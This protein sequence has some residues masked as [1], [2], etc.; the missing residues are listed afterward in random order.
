MSNAVY[1]ALSRQ[2]GLSIEIQKVANNLANASTTGYK[3]DRAVFSEYIVAT[4]PDSDSLSMGRLVG[5]SIELGQ[6]AMRFTGGQLDVAIE[7]EGFFTVETDR[8]VRLSR[9]GHFQLS[10]EGNLIDAN[11]YGVLSQGGGAIAI[12]QGAGQISI[13]DDGT[14]SADGNVIDQIGVVTTEGQLLRDADTLFI[15]QGGYQPATEAR[16]LQGALEQSNVSPVMEVTRMIEVQRAYEAGQA[17]LERE[18][19]R[20]TQLITAMRNQ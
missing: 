8:G 15:A 3:A 19:Q 9:A 10:A 2:Q 14:I 20:L 5:E 13:G 18:D 6:G 11:G 17:M 7:G 12:P 1:A 4:G 16:V